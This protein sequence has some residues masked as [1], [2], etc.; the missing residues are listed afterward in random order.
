MKY[1][2]NMI[3]E[4]IICQKKIKKTMQIKVVYLSHYRGTHG[5]M[6]KTKKQIIEDL[7]LIDIV[8]EILDARIPISSKNPDVEQYSKNKKKIV[9]LNK[10]DLADEN[11]TKQWVQYFETKGIPTIS[12]QSNIAK[13]TEKLINEIK[14][15]AQEISEKYKEKGRIGYTTK[16]M[17][18]GIPN[19]GK[20]TFINSLTKRKTAKVENRPGVTQKKQWIKLGDNIELMDTPGMLWPKIGDENVGMHLAFTNNISKNAVDNEEIAYYL[21][22][23]LLE[24]YPN[25]IIKRYDIDEVNPENI[26][27]TM[28]KIALKKGCIMAGKR[29]DTEKVSNMILNDFQTGKIGRISIEK[30]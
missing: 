16:V 1:R 20:S 14:K 9:V 25:N 23:Y 29:I 7:K 19:V 26:I 8:V 24:N 4:V 27:E 17:V 13:G 3:K 11:I 18:V 10:S 6:A 21:L 2:K 12:M 30:P 15:Q 5:H 22:K 28:E